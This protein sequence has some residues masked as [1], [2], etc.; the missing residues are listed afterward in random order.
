MINWLDNKLTR[1]LNIMHMTPSVQKHPDLKITIFIC[2]EDL[3]TW[4]PNCKG[5]PLVKF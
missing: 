3:K 4:I 5:S 2:L 1:L